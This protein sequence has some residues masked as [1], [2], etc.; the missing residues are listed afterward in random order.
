LLLFGSVT[1]YVHGAEIAEKQTD[2]GFYAL[3]EEER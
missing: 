2:W 3:L 1:T